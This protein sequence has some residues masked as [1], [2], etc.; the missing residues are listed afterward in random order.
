MVGDVHKSIIIIIIDIK[1]SLEVKEGLALCHNECLLSVTVAPC[2]QDP[3]IPCLTFRGSTAGGRKSDGVQVSHGLA[4][5][6]G[7]HLGVAGA[8][9]KL[10]SPPDEGEDSLPLHEEE[11]SPDAWRQVSRERRR[12]RSAHLSGASQRT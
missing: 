3:P 7:G 8:V 5:H 1:R 4:V 2:F 11:L 12:K 6:L 10:V 9:R